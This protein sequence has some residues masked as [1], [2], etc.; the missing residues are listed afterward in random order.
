MKL[1]LQFS[2]STSEEPRQLKV[3]W[4]AADAYKQRV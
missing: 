3:S 4:K 2:V 1:I